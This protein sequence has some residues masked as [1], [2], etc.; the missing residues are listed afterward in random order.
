MKRILSLL[1]IVLMIF[2]L[3][4]CSTDSPAEPTEKEKT[5]TIGFAVPTLQ[6]E[7][8]V[9]YSS[10]IAEMLEAE[11]YTVTVTSYDG[12]ASKLISTIET[13]TVS[14]VDAII[15]MVMDG[16]S[17]A[18]LKAAMDAGIKVIVPGVETE[19]NDLVL[20]ADNADVGKQIGEMAADFVNIQLGGSAQVLALVS[21]ASSDMANRSNGM[22]EAFRANAPEAEIVVEAT[23]ANVGDATNAMENALQQYPD[24]KVVISFGDQGAIEAVNALKAAGKIGDE[25]GAFGCDL[26]QEGLKLIQAGDIFRGTV[27]MGNI[28]DDTARLTLQLLNGELSP[29]PY[30]Y[31]GENKKVTIENVADYIQ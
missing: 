26:T 25:Y 10:G 3:T 24:I 20:V 12:D 23:Y 7:F 4:A 18:A 11:G 15:A 9:W 31:V 1:A 22:L 16:S 6:S 17:E 5:M 29:L 28:V 14:N 21:T 13:F 30:K 19:N 27:D 8:F 2:S